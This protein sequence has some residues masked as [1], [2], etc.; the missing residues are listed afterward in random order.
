MNF[1]RILISLILGILAALA[2]FRLAILTA[3]VWVASFLVAK[4]GVHATNVTL[5]LTYLAIDLL[6]WSVIAYLALTLGSRHKM[7]SSQH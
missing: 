7:R 6:F 2:G 3:P 5:N 4:T 1:R